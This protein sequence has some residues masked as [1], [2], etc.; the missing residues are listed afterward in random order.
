MSECPKLDKCPF[1]TD[2]LANMPSVSGYLKI[3]FCKD[4]YPACARYLV[5]QSLGAEYVP[6]DLFPNEKIRANEI[7]AKANYFN[8]KIS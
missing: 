8:K 2:K 4:A 6:I 3:Q 5:A 1:F 7:I